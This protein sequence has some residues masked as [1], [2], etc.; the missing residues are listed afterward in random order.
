[1]YTRN[2]KKTRRMETKGASKIKDLLPLYTL[3]GQD[4]ALP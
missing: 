1:M 4:Q 2:G 3:D